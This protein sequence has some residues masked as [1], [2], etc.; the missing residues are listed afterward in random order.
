MMKRPKYMAL[1]MQQQIDAGINAFAMQ[2]MA[3]AH[4]DKPEKW[5]DETVCLV[6]HTHSGTLVYMLISTQRPEPEQFEGWPT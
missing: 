1:T 5:G 3:E 4:A 6:G 2:L